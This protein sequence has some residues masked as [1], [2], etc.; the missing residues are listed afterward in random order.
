MQR[1]LVIFCKEPVAGRVKTRLAAEIGVVEATRFQRVMLQWLVRRLRPDPRWRTWL[2]VAPDT[3]LASPML[4]AGIDRVAQ[5]TG[6][7]GQ[8]MQ[9]AFD[10]LPP[11]PVVI[12][13]SDIPGISAGHVA[14]AFAALGNND[15]VVGPAPDGGYWL[16]GQK[17]LPRIR[18]LFADV[19]WSTAHAL[20]DTSANIGDARIARVVQLDDVDTSTSHRRWRR[21]INMKGFTYE[22]DLSKT[23]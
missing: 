14:G 2:A 21:E 10:I 12:I 13:G 22:Q 1:H 15:V 4:P 11:G 7:L 16:I 6:D 18:R 20:A 8:R 19:R 5:G 17:R 3:A 23:S 9:R